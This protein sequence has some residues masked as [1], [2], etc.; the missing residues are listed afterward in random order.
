MIIVCNK[1]LSVI[2]YIQ[3]IGSTE[4]I[5]VYLIAVLIGCMWHTKYRHGEIMN[6]GAQS[7]KCKTSSGKY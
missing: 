7:C 5:I 6:M 2:Q 4:F 3:Y 1:S